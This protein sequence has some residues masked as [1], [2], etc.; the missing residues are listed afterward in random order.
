MSTISIQE[1]T[2]GKAKE[3]TSAAYDVLKNPP[4][5]T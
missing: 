2:E 5:T 3:N 4:W 1:K